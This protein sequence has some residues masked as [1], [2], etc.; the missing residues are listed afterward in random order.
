MAINYSAATG[1]KES[2]YSAEQLAKM[3]ARKQ[4]QAEAAEHAYDP[5]KSTNWTNAGATALTVLPAV[6][7][8]F[9]AK[10][11][12]NPGAT[13]GAKN[14]NAGAKASWWSQAFPNLKDMFSKL[15]GGKSAAGGTGLSMAPQGFDWSSGSGL[16]LFGKNVGKVVPWAAGAYYGLDALN[17]YNEATDIAGSN[18]D[19]LDK[20]TVSAMNNPLVGQYL[21]AD[22]LQ[23]LNQIKSGNYGTDLD[24][25]SILESVVKGIP[26]AILPTA[27]G[28][29]TGSIPGA[30]AAGV[31]SLASSGVGGLTEDASASNAELSAL[32]QALVDAEAQ[33]RAMRRPNFTGLGIQQQYQNMYA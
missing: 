3:S 24:T 28:F 19:L 20:I 7:G 4:A 2:A 31:G 17:N 14:P 21:T 23:L 5:T 32:Y 29:L 1:R 8:G 25:S 18:E 22:Q 26:N 30:I 11:G 12:A 16:K 33:Y 9:N 6:T 27:L 15:F 10:T 13:P